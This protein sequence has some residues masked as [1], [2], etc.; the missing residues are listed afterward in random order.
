MND[1]AR[2]QLGRGRGIGEGIERGLAEQI[3]AANEINLELNTLIDL[4]DGTRDDF[5]P[6]P[7]K[8]GVDLRVTDAVD[9]KQRQ[10]GAHESCFLKC[11]LK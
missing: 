3:V 2:Q 8:P 6:G 9:A 10:A 4:L 7:L 1:R 11:N 5:G